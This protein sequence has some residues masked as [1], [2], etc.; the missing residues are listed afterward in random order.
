MPVV[1]TF[2]P[3]VAGVGRMHYQTFIK[4]NV[5]AVFIW[6]AGAT[7][8][9]YFLGQTVSKRRSLSASDHHHNRSALAPARGD[10]ACPAQA[11]SP[12]GPLITACLPAA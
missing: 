8:L 11:P 7:L 1:R 4:Y 10:T 5:I 2:A 12:E 3:I 6:G 9:G